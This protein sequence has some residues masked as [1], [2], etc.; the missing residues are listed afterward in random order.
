MPK[1]VRVILLTESIPSIMYNSCAKIKEKLKKSRSAKSSA[2]YIKIYEINLKKY[3]T[4]INLK[5]KTNYKFSGFDLN[6]N[7][8]V[9][10]LLVN[11]VE[12][13]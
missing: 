1:P 2:W 9:D 10:L 4:K 11:L 12:I 13:Y 8:E 6:A 7:F 5:K 3:Y